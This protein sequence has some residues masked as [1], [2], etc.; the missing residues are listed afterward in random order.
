MEEGWKTM[1]KKMKLH[2]KSAL[3]LLK[4]LSPRI[5]CLSV[6]D[7][8]ELRKYERVLRRL[9]RGTYFFSGH[10]EE[11][12]V[13]FPLIVQLDTW[14]SR[15]FPLEGFAYNASKREFFFG[16]YFDDEFHDI[17]PVDR[18]IIFLRELRKHGY[19]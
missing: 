5:E 17:Q 15:I 8:P 12:G 13:A 19:I 7:Y 3:L 10:R 1:A 14:W 18:M 6:E 11:E 16:S 9:P 2:D 4:I